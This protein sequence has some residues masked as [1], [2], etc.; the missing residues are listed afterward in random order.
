MDLLGGI[1][2][3]HAENGFTSLAYLSLGWQA[4]ELAVL[5]VRQFCSTLLSRGFILFILFHHPLRSF[6]LLFTKMNLSHYHHI[7]ILVC[8]T[9]EKTSGR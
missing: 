3:S 5:S 8:G 6:L 1:I 4:V 2:I 7:H 9:R